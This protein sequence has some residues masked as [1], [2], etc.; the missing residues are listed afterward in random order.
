MWLKANENMS[1]YFQCRIPG[2]A[3]FW[4]FSISI[5]ICGHKSKNEPFSM[6]NWTCM[7][8][9]LVLPALHRLHQIG[10]DTT[11]MRPSCGS[12]STT[13]NSSGASKRSSKTNF[14]EKI[15]NG[16]TNESSFTALSLSE[17]FHAF[18]CKHCGSGNGPC[19]E[20]K[21]SRELLLIQEMSLGGPAV[22]MRYPPNSTFWSKYV[23]IKKEM[24]SSSGIWRFITM[25]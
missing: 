17:E 9:K 14:Q 12:S 10:F 22:S 7:K 21:D 2:K 1:L 3:D 25:R 15:S 6:N 13:G 11:L 24:L 20:H 5:E 8:I 19:V 4:Y 23:W 18:E 16:R